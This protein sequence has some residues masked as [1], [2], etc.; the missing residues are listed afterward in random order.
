MNTFAAFLAAEHLQ[1]LLREA[2]ADRLRR[3]ARAG[4]RPSTAPAVRSP[5]IGRRVATVIRRLRDI[6]TRPAGPRGAEA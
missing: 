6:F 3:I 2:E 5:G 4:N 1:D